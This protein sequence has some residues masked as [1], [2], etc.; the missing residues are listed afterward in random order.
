MQPTA[1]QRYVHNE[2]GRP[3]VLVD[4]TAS[5]ERPEDRPDCPLRNRE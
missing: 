3:R 4:Q 1:P 5:T 2:A